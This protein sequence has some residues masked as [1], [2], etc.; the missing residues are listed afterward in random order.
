MIVKKEITYPG[1]EELYTDPTAWLAKVGENA[2]LY[3]RKLEFKKT[4]REWFVAGAR[5]DSFRGPGFKSG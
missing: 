2:D 1:L 3:R 4:N 5:L